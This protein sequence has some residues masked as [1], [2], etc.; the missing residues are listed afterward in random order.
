[1]DNDPHHCCGSKSRRCSKAVLSLASEPRADSL[2]WFDSPLVQGASQLRY[3][4]KAQMQRPGHTGQKA[5]ATK[6]I[7]VAVR[8]ALF[9]SS[10][11][12]KSAGCCADLQL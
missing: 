5:L 1:M 3:T 6:N 10:I 8:A 7:A 12:P 9:T 2:P 4:D 11:L